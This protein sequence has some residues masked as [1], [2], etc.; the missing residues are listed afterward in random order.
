MRLFFLKSSLRPVIAIG[1]ISSNST[2][3]KYE[4]TGSIVLVD[5]IVHSNVTVIVSQM[6]TNDLNTKIFS[7][8]ASVETWRLVDL[9]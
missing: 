1:K 2:D 6:E 9:E 5:D 7:S 3:G 8:Q 4:Q